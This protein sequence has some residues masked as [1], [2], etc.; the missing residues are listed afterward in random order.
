MTRIEYLETRID[1]LE[2]RLD[3][4]LGRPRG[5]IIM[6][7]Y[8][9][10]CETGDRETMRRFLKQEEKVGLA[11]KASENGGDTI[12]GGVTHSVCP[13]QHYRRAAM[14]K[15]DRAR[16]QREREALIDIDPARLI[17]KTDSLFQRA[18]KLGLAT[19]LPFNRD[20]RRREIKDAVQTERKNRRRSSHD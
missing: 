12:S 8:R 18:K 10:A 2:T 20:R 15:A 5:P 13:A 4:L 9:I 14:H 7:E 6:T 1:A 16:I 3:E 17:L 19:D 11:V